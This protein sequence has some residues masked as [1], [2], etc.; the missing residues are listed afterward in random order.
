MLN[1]IN[2]Y[3]CVNA[4]KIKI[5]DIDD[6]VFEGSFD[7]IDYADNEDPELGFNEDS[8]CIIVDNQPIGIPQSEIKSIEII[9]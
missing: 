1:M 8:I 6:Q 4:K 7:C 2:I 5:I 9:E 3:D